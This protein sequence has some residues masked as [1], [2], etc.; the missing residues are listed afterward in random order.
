L[1]RCPGRQRFESNAVL[2]L[3]DKELLERSPTENESF[4]RLWQERGLFIG[5]ELH[6]S[7]LPTLP[8]G[9]SFLVCSESALPALAATPLP[10][11]VVRESGIEREG[12]AAAGV[13]G[14]I[15]Q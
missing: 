14:W 6:G 7:P 8:N 1:N 2:S 4:L 3:L 15:D 11:F 13:L 5:L 10:K 9:L 12:H